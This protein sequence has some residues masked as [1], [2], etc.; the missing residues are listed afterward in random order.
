MTKNTIVMISII[1]TLV[2]V[3]SALMMIPI[4]RS[5]IT[6]VPLHFEGLD[7][8]S[9]RADITKLY[10]ESTGKTLG[11]NELYDASFLDVSGHVMVQYFD[12]S[13]RVLLVHFIIRA[14]DYESLSSYES[15][16]EKTQ[17]YFNKVLSRLPKTEAKLPGGVCWK[18]AKEHINYDMYE[19]AFY[20]DESGEHFDGD[21]KVTVFQFNNTYSE[22]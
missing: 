9:T 7:K 21:G 20:Y 22:E 16:V 1:A 3:F 11:G 12:N 5:Y 18:N 19:T 17:D 15:D 14:A 13:D 10:G 6:G 8:V 2:I 4:T